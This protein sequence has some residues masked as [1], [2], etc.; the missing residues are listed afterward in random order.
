MIRATKG[1]NSTA[2]GTTLLLPLL[3]V[4]LAL[5]AATPSLATTALSKTRVWDFSLENPHHDRASDD[6][7]HRIRPENRS[8]GLENASVSPL[9]TRGE[10]LFRNALQAF[11]GGN[12]TNVGRALS[13]HPEVVNLTKE[14]LTKTLR[15]PQAINQ[16]AST[17]LENIMRMGVRTTPTIG[18]YGQVIQY[19]IPGGFGARWYGAGERLGEFIGFINP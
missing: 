12:L 16:A 6:L 5:T 19:Q 3:L 8:A 10:P 9:A 1:R 2:L 15:N 13:K 4:M 7:T 11:K 14:T 17:V 18:R